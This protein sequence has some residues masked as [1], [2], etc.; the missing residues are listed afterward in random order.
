MKAQNLRAVALNDKLDYSPMGSRK[1][2]DSEGKKRT[3]STKTESS[4]ESD[5]NSDLTVMD[6]IGESLRR[7]CGEASS[8]EEREAL[9]RMCMGCMRRA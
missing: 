3:T 1:E 7:R 8:M 5:A 2:A 9:F 6:P 4:A